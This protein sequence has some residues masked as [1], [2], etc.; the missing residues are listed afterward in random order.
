MTSRPGPGLRSRMRAIVSRVLAGLFVATLGLAAPIAEASTGR[1][2]GFAVEQATSRHT[3]GRVTLDFEPDL[4]D[5]AAMLAANIPAWWSEIER[6][7]ARDV[8]DTLRITLVD[9]AGR[10]AEA[11]GMPHWVAGVARSE[12]GEIVIARHGPDGARTD[13]E[14]LLKH[15][16]GHVVLH[17]ASGG[18]DV[19]RWFHEGIA[20]SGAGGISLGRA[21]TLASAVFGPGVPDMERLEAQF[22]GSDG[23]D[24]A[25]AYAAA[26]DLVEFLRAQGEDGVKLRQAM[27]EL[28]RGESFEA[29]IARAYGKPL[30]ELV[31][32]W[33]SG[34]PAR[35]VGYPM[36]AGG[37]LPLALVFPLVL[38]AWIRKRREVKRGWDRLEREDELMFAHEA[39]P[40][41]IFTPA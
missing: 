15:E 12:T 38:V 1:A 17:R 26:R 6:P 8:D 28:R 2:E 9:H 39:S 32:V 19:P 7:L 18:A 25:V 40:A 5:E 41:T 37:G 35:F 16:M 33:R 4:A 22:Y 36:V 23:Q 20:E 30:G 13:L 11:T 10:V 29:A 14:H 3:I 21:Q 34:L 24:V 31:Q 27:S